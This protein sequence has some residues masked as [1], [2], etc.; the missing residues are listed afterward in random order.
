MSSIPVIIFVTCTVFAFII[1]NLCKAGIV[2]QIPDVR[3]EPVLPKNLTSIRND[4]EKPKTSAYPEEE[5]DSFSYPGFILDSNPVCPNGQAYQ[6][7]E[8]REAE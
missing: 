3:D 5:I 2:G 1:A 4:T 8:C 6:Y 7:G